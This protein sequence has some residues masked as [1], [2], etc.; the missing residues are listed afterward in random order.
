MAG[1]RMSAPKNKPPASPVDDNRFWTLY[2]NAFRLRCP[3]CK[4]GRIFRGW[5]G[6][7]EH[8]PTCAVKVERESGF[9]LGSIYFNYGSTSVLLFASYLIGRFRL[10]APDRYLM[11]ALAIFAIVYPLYFLRYARASFM[12]F[13]QYFNPRRPE[14]APAG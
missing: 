6:L 13:D 3:V 10:G 2:F 9:L 7:E 8:C 4:Q 12:A 1:S 5:F 11:P 14:N